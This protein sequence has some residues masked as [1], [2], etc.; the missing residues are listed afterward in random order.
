MK[1]TKALITAAAKSQRTLP[2]QTLV[3]RDGVPRT[4]LATSLLHDGDLA[5]AE[6]V[7]REGLARDAG[8]LEGNFLLGTILAKTDRLDEA[9]N[10][11]LVALERDDADVATLL[12][13]GRLERAANRPEEARSRYQQV[14][15][16]KDHVLEAHIAI[17]E[18]AG[19][20]G[21]DE[22]AVWHLWQARELELQE[23]DK[24]APYA[25]R[26]LALYERLAARERARVSAPPSSVGK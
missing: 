5:Q 16:H 3:D 24:A 25:A 8:D 6:A 14:L 10:A 23:A 22:V 15:L 7:A 26:L 20:A 17:A 18:I 9:R 4:A 12:A 2:L 21:D 13:L 1:I 11:F 19:A